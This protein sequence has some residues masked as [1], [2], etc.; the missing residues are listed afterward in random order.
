MAPSPNYTI[1]FEY[2]P[3]CATMVSS[4]SNYFFSDKFS[5]IYCSFDTTS[6]ETTIQ[7]KLPSLDVTIAETTVSC[8]RRFRVTQA[9]GIQ[10]DDSIV[11]HMKFYEADGFDQLSPGQYYFSCCFRLFL[12]FRKRHN[13]IDHWPHYR[14]SYQSWV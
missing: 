9:V 12:N 3:C 11:S 10:G 2:L 6:L 8:S 5:L 7:L 1:S 14:C 13:T 4:F